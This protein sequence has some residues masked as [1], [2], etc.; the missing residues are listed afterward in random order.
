MKRL[1][2]FLA[3]LPALAFAQSE[4]IITGKVDGIADGDVKIS[5]T[6]DK[7]ILAT[8]TIKNGI[9][10]VKGSVAEPALYWITF[11]NEQEQH[12]Y[13]ENKPIKVSGTKKDL[14]NFK[15]E[16][17]ASHKDFELFRNTFNPLFG[18]LNALAAQLQKEDNPKKKEVLKSQ[19]DSVSKKA[20]REVV[21][22]ITT[23]KASFVSP[24]LLFV[25]AQLSDDI[26]LL[27]EHYNILD[28]NIRNSVI[29]RG[30]KDYID[31]NKIGALGTPAVDFTQ[32]DPE[33]NPV[34]LSSFK[35]KYVLVDFWASW[36]R[37]CRVEN[38]NVVKAFNKFKDKNFTV[39]GISLDQEKEAWI[40]A[41]EKDKLKWTQVSD[42]QFWNNAVAQLYH[43]QSIPQNFLVDPNGKIIAKNLSGEEL[44]TKLC[45]IL[46][47]CN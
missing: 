12:I 42:L 24:F 43:V 9:V 34:A 15:V 25:T 17:S 38:P 11:G 8:G 29:G 35:G 6:M 26:L 31:Y 28:E 3:M 44:Q 40:K 7:T 45:E 30:L 22:F 39:L 18:E 23:K 27:E 32:N 21:K 2:F 4:F 33:G 19:Y 37:P 16:G 14:K 36:C 41:I 10:S 5:S 13:L 20:S 47:G 1:L 46:G